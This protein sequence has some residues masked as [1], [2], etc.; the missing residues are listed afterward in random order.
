M[1]NPDPIV[2]IQNQ[3]IKS[4]SFYTKV[5]QAKCLIMNRQMKSELKCDKLDAKK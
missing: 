1:A 3:Q 2:S 4:D 5:C